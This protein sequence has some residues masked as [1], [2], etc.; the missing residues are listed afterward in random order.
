MVVRDRVLRAPKVLLHDHLDGGLRPATVLE[1]ADEIGHELPT[2]DETELTA[3]FFQGGRGADLVRYLEAFSH[4]VALLQTAPALQRVARECAEDLAADGVVHAEIRFAPELSTREGLSIDEVIEA[5]LDG[6]AAGPGT[7]G[8]RM[9][10]CGMRQEDRAG[11][12][13]AAAARFRDRGVVAVDLA[14]PED[15]FPASRHAG[16]LRQAREDGLGLTLHAGEAAG[17]ESIADAL[18]QG[19]HRIGHG[20]RIVEDLGPDDEPGPVARRVLL[21]SVPLEV[22]PVSNVHT[23]ISPDIASHPVDRL[24]RAGFAV[25]IST[26]NRLM[27]GTSATDELHGLTEAFGYDLDDL[28]ALTH[29]AASAAFLGSTERAELRD[30]IDRGYAALVP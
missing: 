14:G 1:L 21:G 23:G 17:P 27:S 19:A 22:C 26:D 6:F 15:G 4:T 8:T 16:A 2:T 18:D 12:A 20:V 30:R 7:I 29:A 10:V 24:R 3:W 5:C 9:I 13:F 28:R 25:T 11:E